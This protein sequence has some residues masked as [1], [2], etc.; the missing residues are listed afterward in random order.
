MG[1]F[2]FFIVVCKGV[3]GVDE[4]YFGQSIV[5][6]FVL[7]RVVVIVLSRVYGVGGEGGGYRYGIEY[8]LGI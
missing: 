2:K 5:S 3:F 1:S 8:K 7:N 4:G 6:S